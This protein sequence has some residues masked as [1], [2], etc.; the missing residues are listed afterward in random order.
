M[1][2]K[3]D[4][5]DKSERKEISAVM[6]EVVEQKIMPQLKKLEKQNNGIMEQVAKNSEDIKIIKEDFKDM[7]YTLERIETRLD[8]VIRR[9]DDSS[10]KTS[11]LQRRV[12]RLETK[13]T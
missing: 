11:Q 7:G 3:G 6:G 8:S 10:I 4:S 13:K 1:D 2:S 12:L 5:M 9:Q